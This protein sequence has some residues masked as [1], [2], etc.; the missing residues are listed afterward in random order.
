MAPIEDYFEA[1]QS[2]EE[3]VPLDWSD[4][5]QKFAN[6][7]ANARKQEMGPS[8]R[9]LRNLIRQF[10]R[11]S[12]K[13]RRHVIEDDL[14][15]EQVLWC[16]Q[17]NDNVMPDPNEPC[18][19]VFAIPE[20]VS[21]AREQAALKVRVYPMHNDL[22]LKLWEGGAR[23]A[24]Y[25]IVHPHLVEGKCLVEIGSGVGLTGIA[26]AGCCRAK[27]IHMTDYT[28]ASIQ[29]LHR[30]LSINQPWLDANPAKASVT[31]VSKD[32]ACS[33]QGCGSIV[34]Q[35]QRRASHLFYS[36][37]GYLDWA[38]FSGHRMPSKWDENFSLFHADILLAADVIYD[39]QVI[40][41]LVDLVWCFLAGA[42]GRVAIFAVTIRNE[43]TFRIFESAMNERHVACEY[44][45][46]TEAAGSCC[47]SFRKIF[48]I[49][50]LGSVRL[51]LLS[52]MTGWHE[53]ATSP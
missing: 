38:A 19:Q 13:E 36:S 45:R 29:N 49:G 34:S 40:A 17:R 26:V 43:D 25:L 8:E 47:H 6:M 28:E 16:S 20:A 42:R 9:Y 50:Q 30:N 14:L 52:M 46:N 35:L 27:R 33:R 23:L 24:E 7:I 21:A 53:A 4:E 51:F 22:G 18:Y 11:Q 39:C 44:V 48:P 1:F 2:E 5:Q 31:I 10:V 32:A 12:E 37:E 15:M 3:E 41:E